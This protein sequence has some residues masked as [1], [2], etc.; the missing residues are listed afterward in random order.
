M[1]NALNCSKSE[2]QRATVEWQQHDDRLHVQLQQQA[3]ALQQAHQQITA[4]KAGHDAQ[5]HC[6]QQKHA[7]VSQLDSVMMQNSAVADISCKQLARSCCSLCMA[8]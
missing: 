8:L 6:M 4:L 1:Q 7:E 5:Q 3:D 2:Q